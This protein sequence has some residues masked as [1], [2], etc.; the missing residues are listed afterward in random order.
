MVVE[1][2]I[3]VGKLLL[4]ALSLRNREGHAVDGNRLSGVDVLRHPVNEIHS[5]RTILFH[6]LETCVAQLV[7]RLDEVS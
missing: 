6:H 3:V 5:L 4:N 2:D 7:G 1:L